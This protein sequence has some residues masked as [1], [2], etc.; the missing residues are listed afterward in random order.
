MKVVSKIINIAYSLGSV[1]VSNISK[2]IPVVNINLKSQSAVSVLTKSIFAKAASKTINVAQISKL[3]QVSSFSFREPFYFSAT[4]F[5]RKFDVG[6]GGFS[7]PLNIEQ[8]ESQYGSEKGQI[9]NYNTT[10]DFIH[11]VKNN[12]YSDLEA[13][14]P[15]L[16]NISDYISVIKNYKGDAYLPQFNYN[17]I[18]FLSHGQGYQITVVKPFYMKIK[19]SQYES[20]EKFN[21]FKWQIKDGDFADNNNYRWHYIGIPSIVSKNTE[22]FFSEFIKDDETFPLLVSGYEVSSYR[23]LILKD[24][25]GNTSLPHFNYF[26]VDTLEPGE[27]YTMKV[28]FMP[29]A[30]IY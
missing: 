14:T 12:F 23:L 5:T 16:E 15:L 11:F 13:T 18:G 8:I 4:T 29:E 25:N 20:I 17:G 3:I 9:L 26:N 10:Y 6:N 30:N 27:Y 7:I 28:N 1:F 2:V 24:I 22:Q 21:D 19:G